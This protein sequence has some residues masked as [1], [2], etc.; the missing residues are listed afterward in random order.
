MRDLKGFNARVEKGETGEEIKK[1]LPQI[2]IIIDE[3][4]DK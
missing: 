1:N 4:A 2:L 3:L